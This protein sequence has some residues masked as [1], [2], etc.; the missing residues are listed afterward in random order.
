LLGR[1]VLQHRFANDLST[2]D[3]AIDKSRTRIHGFL[4]RFLR[5]KGIDDDT[6][7]TMFHDIVAR[8]RSIVD[9]ADGGVETP[10]ALRNIPKIIH[11][12]WLTD[13]S[14]PVDPPERHIQK[15]MSESVEYADNGWKLWLWTA[16]PGL[17]SKTIGCLQANRAPIVVKDYREILSGQLWEEN[18]KKLLADRKFP[19]ASDLLRMKLLHQYG[20]VYA[21][22]GARLKER[23]LMEFVADNFDYA[24]IFWETL[25]FQNSLMIMAPNSHVGE[26]YME[27][28]NEPY[29]LP[30]SLFYPLDG[31]EEGMAFSGLLIT[32]LLLFS[33]PEN[34][35]VCP[36][37]PNGEVVEWISERSWYTRDNGSSGKFGNTYVPESGA[38]FLSKERFE[39]GRP[40]PIFMP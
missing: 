24:L 8:A 23:R 11:R 29:G 12:I 10:A 27:V 4:Q 25:F 21:D 33:A 18:F 6:A 35:R 20:G 34:F 15:M 26:L 37:A 28:A 30:K 17:I 7:I 5:R 39:N 9:D 1:D 22:M 32:A 36:L 14:N 38:S 3:D 2:I 13:S 19:F 16:D 31:L 40:L